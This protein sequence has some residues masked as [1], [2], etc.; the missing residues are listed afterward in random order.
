MIPLLLL[1][2]LLPSTFC[3]ICPKEYFLVNDSKCLKAAWAPATHAH[4]EA[5]CTESGGTLVNIKNAIDN[6]AVFDF[7]NTAGLQS[8]WIGLSCFSNTTSSCF[9]DDASGSAASYSN[10]DSLGIATNAGSRNCVYMMVAN[11]YSGKWSSKI[12]FNDIS[13]TTIGYICEAPPSV[14]QSSYS[15]M[16]PVCNHNYNRNCY[17]RSD[18]YGAVYYNQSWANNFCWNMGYTSLASIHSKIDV[19]FIRSL[20]KGTNTTQV[21][22]GAMAETA[23]R[24]NW[25]DGTPWDFN[26][27]DPLNFQKAK[28]LVMD[29]Q[30]DGL[31]SPMDCDQKLPF[32]CSR[33]VKDT[34]AAIAPEA[35]L[36]EPNI[37]DASNCNSTLILAPGSISSFGYPGTPSGTCIWQIRTLGPYRLGIYFD[38]WATLG[39]LSIYDEFEKN[40]GNVSGAYYT[41][42]FAKYTPF[43]IAKVV[44]EARR[45]PDPNDRGFHAVIMMI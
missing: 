29:V 6:R 44:Y 40:I 9:W 2:L 30:G 21:Y 19:D 32:L 14:D 8:I 45:E 31:W 42:P 37:L 27:M 4:A 26:Y 34:S 16:S 41:P 39:S 25:M 7:A 1:F 43:N 13:T 22:I 17:M 18:D 12:C 23:D 35:K 24:F 11:G 28:C 15:P 5:N 36:Q 33:K 20:Y 3:L 38:L 10:F